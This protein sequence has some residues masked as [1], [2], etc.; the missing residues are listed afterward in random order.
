MP[1]LRR[2]VPAALATV[3]VALLGACGG[4]DPATGASSGA[5]GAA[6]AEKAGGSDPGDVKV[7]ELISPETTERVVGD[8]TG[9]V[10]EV[11]AVGGLGCHYDGKERGTLIVRVMPAEDYDG[12]DRNKTKPVSGL[13]DKASEWDLGRLSYTLDAVQGEMYVQ[14]SAGAPVSES[15]KIGGVDKAGIREAMAEALKSL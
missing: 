10:Q 6:D 11:D 3:A 9:E 8:S 7:C 15:G 14:L 1:R 13:G 12:L 2:T 4:D 5:G